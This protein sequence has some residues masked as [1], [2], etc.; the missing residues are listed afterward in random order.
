MSILRRKMFRGGGY[1]HR[2]TGIT[3]GLV[4]RYEHGGLHTDDPE[5]DKVFEQRQ[6]ILESIYPEPTKYDRFGANVEPLMKFFSGLMRGQSYQGGLGGGLE[7]A[8]QALD[9]AAPGFGKAIQERKKLEAANRAEKLQM[10]LMAYK[11]AEDIIA[12]RA[13]AKAKAKPGEVKSVW[14]MNPDFNDEAPVSE[15]NKKYLESTRRVGTDYILRIKDVTPG[16]KTFGEYVPED[17]FPNYMVTDPVNTQAKKSGDLWIM[18]PAYE[19]KDPSNKFLNSKFKSDEF[20][21]VEILD[22]I[23]GSPTENDYIPEENFTNF[24]YTEPKEAIK[25]EK[26]K[27]EKTRIKGLVQDEFDRINKNAGRDTR[28]L[29]DAELNAILQRAGTKE[30]DW[31][32][33]SQQYAQTFNELGSILQ[34]Y[35]QDVDQLRPEISIEFGDKEEQQSNVNQKVYDMQTKPDHIDERFG[36]DKTDP[37]YAIKRERAMREYR[38][39]DPIPGPVQDSMNAAFAGFKDLKMMTDNIREGVP[40]VGKIKYITSAF[41]LD[42]GATEFI[43]GQRGTLV[44]STAALIKGIPSDF[45]VKNLKATIPS[46]DEG[47]PVNIVR[48]RRLQRIYNDIIKNS[49]AWHAGYGYRI[50][51]AI[52]VKARA[53]IGNEAV[54]EALNTAKYTTKKLEDIQTMSEKEFIDKYEDPFKESLRILKIPESKLLPTLN[55]AEMEELR[56]HEERMGIKK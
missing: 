55:E 44:S 3:S 40:F 33:F 37:N 23:P 24:Q 8:G 54:N 13:A 19:G 47:D 15:E 4:P 22:V 41:G 18:N 39:I 53:I 38:L 50:P 7:I 9:E 21:N 1:A 20:G 34:D 46:I 10:D 26:D 6:K 17:K 36:L 28:V 25:T 27:I 51:E 11:S 30:G 29:K 49:L 45:D 16:S 35:V 48:A 56:L 32:K 14:Y 31:N 2:G 43:T 12:A 52:E 5:F 42:P